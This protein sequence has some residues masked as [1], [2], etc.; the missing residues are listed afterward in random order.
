MS[1]STTAT[2]FRAEVLQRLLVVLSLVVAP[3]LP[4]LPPWLIA[5]TLAFGA[6]CY[7]NTRRS[8]KIPPLWLRILLS[9]LLL[10]AV[11][12][13]YGTLLGRDVGSAL[14]IAM[15]ALKLMEIKA[16]RDIYI[17]VFLGYFLIIVGF[18]FSQSLWMAG[19]M[20]VMVILLTA[21][22]HKGILSV[23]L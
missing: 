10:V 21:V 12:V 5:V 9:T 17:T 14:L 8:L 7:F 15:L 22:L 6:W 2:A 3:Q 11:Y 20:L 23:F 18:L 4:R 16:A 1:R 13:H 19:Y